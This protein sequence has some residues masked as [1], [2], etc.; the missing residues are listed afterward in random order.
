LAVEVV[1]LV[2]GKEELLELVQS[3]PRSASAA[4]DLVEEN[5]VPI[6]QLTKKKERQQVRRWSGEASCRGVGALVDDVSIWIS[7]M[8]STTHDW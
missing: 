1:V 2:C 4:A 5:I 8:K 7:A 3:V 6:V